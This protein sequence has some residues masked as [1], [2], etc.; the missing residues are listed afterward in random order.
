MSHETP[1][2]I[3]TVSADYL[4]QIVNRV[5]ASFDVAALSVEEVIVLQSLLERFNN[6]LWHEHGQSLLLAYRD[7]AEHPDLPEE[8]DEPED[9]EPEGSGG[10]PH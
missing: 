7:V 9:D 2:L 6:A 4:V 10:L 5:A 3:D 8:D 1:P